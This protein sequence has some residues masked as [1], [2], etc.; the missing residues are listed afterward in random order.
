MHNII[1]ANKTIKN[2]ESRTGVIEN[3]ID[4]IDELVQSYKKEVEEIELTDFDVDDLEEINL[5][6]LDTYTVPEEEPET[7]MSRTVLKIPDDKIKSD[8]IMALLYS[9]YKVSL[10]KENFVF[11][12]EGTERFY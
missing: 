10:A 5:E 12:E 9:G 2:L 4:E 6:E 8:I 1:E 11:I 3:S 7:I